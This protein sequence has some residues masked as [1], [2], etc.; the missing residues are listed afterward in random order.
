[1]RIE[2]EEPLKHMPVETAV[3]AIQHQQPQQAAVEMQATIASLHAEPVA[4]VI[5]PVARMQVAEKPLAKPEVPQPVPAPKVASTIAEKA[6]SSPKKASLHEK[7]A[8]KTLNFG[9][10][11]RIAFVKH[12][13]EGNTDD[14]NRVVGQLNTFE[15]WE[16]AENFV[17]EMVKPDYNW[18]GKEEYEG[19]FLASVKAK[20]D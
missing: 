18:N 19:R 10:N 15:S 5:P 14:F 20:F 9:L 6:Q 1:M 2:Q 7:L 17:T 11:D 12:L 4:E 13:F 8:S 3:D 16:E